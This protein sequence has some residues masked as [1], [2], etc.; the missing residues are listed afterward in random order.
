[1]ALHHYFVVVI[2]ADF[3]IGPP[4]GESGAAG[5]LRDWVE[6]DAT[7]FSNFGLFGVRRLAVFGPDRNFVSVAGANVFTI[8]TA[9]CLE[10]FIKSAGVFSLRPRAL[11][12]SV[13]G[14]KHA[15]THVILDIVHGNHLCFLF[16]VNG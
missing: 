8:V 13:A 10:L 6:E 11:I 4:S 14:G 2:E 5:G 9:S 15:Q 1:L 16:I 3:R 12:R 7:V